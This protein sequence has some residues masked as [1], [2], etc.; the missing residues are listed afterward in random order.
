MPSIN[1]GGASAA[2]FQ[3]RIGQMRPSQTTNGG[4]NLY[5]GSSI[6]PESASVNADVV[7][8]TPDN[9]GSLNGEVLLTPQQ[10]KELYEKGSLQVRREFQTAESNEGFMTLTSKLA[11]A[12]VGPSRSV[13]AIQID[14]LFLEMIK[15]PNAKVGMGYTRVEKETWTVLP[16]PDAPTVPAPDRHDPQ[17]RYEVPGEQVYDKENRPSTEVQGEA[18]EIYRI[19]RTPG[20]AGRNTLMIQQYKEQ[21]YPSLGNGE[22]VGDTTYDGATAEAILGREMQV[23]FQYVGRASL[24]F[25][26]AR[27]PGAVSFNQKMAAKVGM[28]YKGIASNGEALIHDK[29]GNPV[30]GDDYKDAVAKEMGLGDFSNFQKLQEQV[31][32]TQAVGYTDPLNATA[33][34][35]QVADQ[36]PQQVQDQL[37]EMHDG[38]SLDNTRHEYFTANDLAN[39][40]TTEGRT[41]LDEYK[42]ATLS[43]PIPD[44]LLDEYQALYNQKNGTDLSLDQ[45]KAA[46]PS[47]MDMYAIHAQTFQPSLG[48]TF[49]D[50]KANIPEGSTNSVLNARIVLEAN[51]SN[52]GEDQLLY[53]PESTRSLIIPTD[54]GP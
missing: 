17:P 8:V 5:R 22:Q 12:L 44:G 1:S 39:F 14:P 47:L 27:L 20:E 54:S 26:N 43:T 29:N 19:A 37:K 25:N 38:F 50:G 9:I 2:Q 32:F 6:I 53:G 35:A 7:T 42:D 21:G 11:A 45:I 33:L 41:R 51:T 34:A 16:S 31:K 13:A 3:N 36:T 4:N 18:G 15:D 10:T 48:I 46:N 40:P 28:E 52:G 30:S 49:T 24:N 23:P